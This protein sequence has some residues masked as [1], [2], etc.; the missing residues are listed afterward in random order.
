MMRPVALIAALTISPLI[1]P[2]TASAQSANSSG[3]KIVQLKPGE[4]A[5][6]GAMTSSVTAGGG[7]VSGHTTGGNSVTVHSGDGTTSSSVTTS[8]SGNGGSTTVTSANG[9]C[10]VYVTPGQKK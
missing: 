8:S 3:C 10:T 4:R 7:K 2:I 6:S 1:G 9:D 5:P